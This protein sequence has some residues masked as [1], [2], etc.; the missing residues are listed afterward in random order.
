MMVDAGTLETSQVMDVPNLLSTNVVPHLPL[1]T[2]AISAAESQGSIDVAEKI[3]SF[4]PATVAESID[5]TYRIIT[6][7]IS[8]DY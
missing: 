8:D 3:T 7:N 4:P 2:V 5:L 6:V 1:L